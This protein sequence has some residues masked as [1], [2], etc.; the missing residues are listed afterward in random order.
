MARP[1]RRQHLVWSVGSRRHGDAEAEPGHP[2]TG[3]EQGQRDRNVWALEAGHIAQPAFFVAEFLLQVDQQLGPRPQRWVAD[4]TAAGQG[5]ADRLAVDQPLDLEP[6]QDRRP[7]LA[8]GGGPSAVGRHLASVAG[9]GLALR[10]LAAHGQALGHG[11]QAPLNQHGGGGPCL[12][13][14]VPHSPA[15]DQD[16][17]LVS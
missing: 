15:A 3:P 13:G 6:V 10:C 14:L 8:G 11:P 7:V 4:Q 2:V 5:R 16:H 1:V 17:R 9:V 12:L